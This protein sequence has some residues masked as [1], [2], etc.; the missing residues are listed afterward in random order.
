M[1]R[2]GRFARRGVGLVLRRPVR[3]FHQLRE[4]HGEWGA[5]DEL[6]GACDEFVVVQP[7]VLVFLGLLGGAKTRLCRRITSST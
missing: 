6:D 1:V 2:H 5:G 7:N 3:V 4:F